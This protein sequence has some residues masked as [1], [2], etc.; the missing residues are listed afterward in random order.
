MVVGIIFP[1]NITEVMI[2]KELTDLKL[3]T[4]VVTLRSSDNETEANPP[5]TS[6]DGK[7][8]KQ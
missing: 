3:Y 4:T 6:V 2:F 5:E 8:V 7:I 1:I